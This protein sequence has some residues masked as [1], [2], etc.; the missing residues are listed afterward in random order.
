MNRL[1][2]G[3]TDDDELEYQRYLEELIISSLIE[4]EEDDLSAVLLDSFENDVKFE[5]NE[6]IKIISN[7][8]RYDAIFD[9]V[10]EISE[11]CIICGEKYTQQDVVSSLKCNHIYHNSCISEWG[12]YVQ[13]CPICRIDIAFVDL[14]K[15]S[16]S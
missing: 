8:I 15:K 7:L 13:K 11:D 2:F 9:D 3:F 14:S 10:S 5:K 12:K 16:N 4:I 1:G 6:N